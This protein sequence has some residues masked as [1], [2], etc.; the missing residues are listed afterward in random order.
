MSFAFG[1]SSK[2]FTIST[3]NDSDRDDESVSLSFGT[4]N[5]AAV[6][7]GSPATATLTIDDTPPVPRNDNGGGNDDGNNND[8]GTTTK[9]PGGSGGGGSSTPSFTPP[10]ANQAPAFSEGAR[11]T[12]EI[13]EKTPEGTNIGDPIA[14]TDADKDNLTYSLG[15]MDAASFTLDTGTGQLKTKA[16]LDFELK[17]TYSLA[18]SVSD[19]RGGKR[20][21]RGDDQR[22]GCGGCSRHQPRHRGR[23]T[24]RPQRRD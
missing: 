20:L 23:G 19:G 12:R 11:T 7:T 4:I 6:G 13:P 5:E 10:P 2:S 17:Y 21:H 8:G 24:G 9:T 18:V 16:E 15:G 1:D 3:T 22:N 14:A